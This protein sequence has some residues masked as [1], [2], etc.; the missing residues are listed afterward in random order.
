MATVDFIQGAALSYFIPLA[1]D[2][3]LQDALAASE[4]SLQERIDAIEP[5]DALFFGELTVRCLVVCLSHAY[6]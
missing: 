3:Q 4:L 2:F 6:S 1:T 5:R